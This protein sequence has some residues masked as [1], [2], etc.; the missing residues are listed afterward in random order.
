[1]MALLN[2]GS[3]IFTQIIAAS[4]HVEGLDISFNVFHIKLC[5]WNVMISNKYIR[6][7]RIQLV[8]NK[9]SCG[10]N[11]DNNQH[12]FTAPYR[13]WSDHYAWH[14]CWRD[15]IN[16]RLKTLPLVPTYDN[17][18]PSGHCS[19]RPIGR[20][21]VLLRPLSDKIYRVVICSRRE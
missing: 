20:D 14:Y 12:C 2:T 4:T 16:T 18:P 19:F 1:M 10:N 9:L 13:L 21:R 6:F 5:L 3:E 17:L 7:L 15:P 8:I 11:Y